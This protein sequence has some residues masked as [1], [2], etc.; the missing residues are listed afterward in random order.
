MRYKYLMKKQVHVHRFR[1]YDDD[2]NDNMFAL[3]GSVVRMFFRLLD[4]EGLFVGA[5]AAL[6]VV[7][8]AKVAKQLGPGHTGTTAEACRSVFRG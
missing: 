6:N 4:E 2:I 3:C 8:A 7:A 1:C 5:S